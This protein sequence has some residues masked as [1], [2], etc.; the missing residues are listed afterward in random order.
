MAQ[1][2][3]V[4]SIPSLDVVNHTLIRTSS[5]ACLRGEL[6]GHGRQV[7]IKVLTVRRTTESDW[8]E[9][10]KEIALVCRVR[11]D[12]VMVPLGIYRSNLFLGLVSEWMGS[13]SLHSL[14][15]ECQLFPELPLPLLLRI[16]L[17]VAEGVCHLH[18]LTPPLLHQALKS[19]N[20]LLDTQNRA[21]VCD[22]GLSQWRAWNL[23]S[24]PA[25]YSGLCSRDVAYLSPETL[26]GEAPS[27]EGDVYSFAI[28]MWETL[29]RRRPYQDIGQPQDLVS[30]VQGGARPNTGE[31]FIPGAVPQRNSLIQLMTQCWHPDPQTR[32]QIR[33]CVLELRR[34]VE[35]FHPDTLSQADQQLKETKE[36]VLEGCKDQLTHVI[37]VEINNLE[38]SSRNPKNAGNKFV[39]TE[40]VQMLTSAPVGPDP[41][42]TSPKTLTVPQ[43]GRR[44]PLEA[45]P[46][47]ESCSF[48]SSLPSMPACP[49]VDG[50]ERQSSPG[51]CYAVQSPPPPPLHR[52]GS[53]SQP[54]QCTLAWFPERSCCRI[55]QARRGSIVRGMTEGRLNYVLD[56]LRSR[57]ALAREDY[58]YITAA[59]TLAARTRCLLDT[60][61]CLGEGTAHL[62]VQALG[63]GSAGGLCQ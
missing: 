13:C 49:R 20:V 1:P 27:A 34:V 63:L 4:L 37:Q 11:S 16:L 33:D 3:S 44:A 15:H 53:F 23:Q 30:S 7:S 52:T 46:Q 47:R 18:S 14:L 36:R 39:P 21:K 19:S 60:C 35:T 58:E 62:V 26:R 45:V 6:R 50:G 41:N 29:S 40:T 9:R 61:L 59:L 55:L 31:A 5:G 32:P 8:T 22:Y 2:C 28:L 56:R 25:D 54:D 43:M 57:Q 38:I 12:Q 51:I 17:D 42:R 48:A 10:L 24:V